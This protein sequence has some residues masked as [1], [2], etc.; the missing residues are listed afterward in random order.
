MKPDPKQEANR[1]LRQAKNDLAAAETLRDGAFYA[2]ACFM[3]QQ[4]A[5][6][7]LKALHYLGGER[8]VLGHS[9]VNLLAGLVERYP[10]LSSLNGAASRLDLYYVTSRYPNSLPGGAPFEVYG[11]EQAEEAVTF[12]GSIIGVVTRLI[13]QEENK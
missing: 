4:A 12:A 5:E 9:A 7:A 2:Q 10:E 13:S 1:W 6:K 3:S 8:H 11:R